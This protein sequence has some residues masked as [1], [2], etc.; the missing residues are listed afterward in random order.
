M[1][2]NMPLFTGNMTNV[3]WGFMNNLDGGYSSIPPLTSANK[4]VKTF[5]SG[6]G[7][8]ESTKKEDRS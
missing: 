2:S 7:K 4:S 8:D 5:S 6:I 1:L 3:Q